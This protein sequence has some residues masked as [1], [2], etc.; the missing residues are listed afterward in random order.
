[1]KTQQT[2]ERWDDIVFEKRNKTYGAYAIRQSYPA[3]VLMSLML[4]SGAIAGIFL[5]P[6]HAMISLSEVQDEIIDAVVLGEKPIIKVDE[7]AVKE[8]VHVKKSATTQVPTRVTVNEIPDYKIEDIALNTP[9]EVDSDGPFDEPIGSALNE[10]TI[11]RD[12]PVETP[13]F[14]LG[15]EVMPA[16]E[17]GVPEIV[18]FIQKKLHYP[19]YAARLEI[20]GTVYVSF[21]VSTSGKVTHVEIVKGIDKGCDEEAMRV[22]SLMDRWKP[23]MQNKRPVAVK[24]VLPIKFTAG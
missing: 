17:G 3:N 6:S 15:A 9:T 19:N 2:D 20:T 16:Y 22:I 11:I 8:K 21:V 4:C 23:G 12:T 1:M 18:K 10:G 13:P 24:M 14:V 5:L 7:I